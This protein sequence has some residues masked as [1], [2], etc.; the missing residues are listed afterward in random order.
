MG[1]DDEGGALASRMVCA[2]CG[3]ALEPDAALPFRCPDAAAGD[4]VD[5][6][7][8]C[9]L[10]GEGLAELFAE[11]AA[12]R[13]PCPFVRFRKLTHSYRLARRQGMGD[14]DYCGLVRELDR[15]VAAVAGVGFV[16][17]PYIYSGGLNLW[18]KDETGNVG[19]SHKA[20]HLMGL[21]IYLEVVE[22][23][24]LVDLG[25][26]ELVIASCGNAALAASIV[27]KAAG[28]RLR[29][30]VPPTAGDEV[31]RIL[32]ANGALREVC[33]RAPEDPPGDPTVRRFRAALADGALPFSCQGDDNGLTIQGGLTL[34]WEVALQHRERTAT[35]LGCL[36]LQVGGGALASGVIEAYALARAAGA[37]AEEPRFVAV[38]TANAHPLLGAFEAVWGRAQ[39]EGIA[40]AMVY[41]RGHRSA[42]MRPWPAPPHSVAD[43]ILD[44]ETYDWAALTE[45]LLRS[46]GRVVLVDEECLVRARAR[47]EVEAGICASATG[48]AGVA[49]ALT[50]RALGDDDCGL[51]RAALVTGT[52]R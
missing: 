46:G 9:E 24:G 49:G 6:V 40:A 21:A 4:D 51:A 18:L 14:A 27:A 17:T 20:R 37:L 48:A 43:G 34:G 30:F 41:A 29:V 11:A 19:G 47:V 8:Q 23:L 22:R 50:T 26:R 39:T 1:V 16:E 12:D 31:V 38:Q 44:D 3:L 2:G 10:G 45:G 13:D 25:G 28:R 42:H 7:L 32:E 15:R 33:A 36:F 35:A 5:H 52:R